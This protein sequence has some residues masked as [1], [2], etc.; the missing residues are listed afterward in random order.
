MNEGSASMSKSRHIR[1][2]DYVNHPY[3]KV[4]DLLRAEALAAF[5]RATKSA[6]ARAETVAAQLHVSIAGI[7][8]GTDI[9]I[10]LHGVEETP[11]VGRSTPVTRLQLEWKARESARL[12][13]LMRAEL[14]V[15]PL[16]ATETQ[17]DFS[18]DY[19]PPLGVVG[20]AVDTLVGHRVAEA[21]IHRFVNEVAEYLRTA[22]R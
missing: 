7:E 20:S 16:T 5:G 2:F 15:Y 6:A 18:G 4:R 14:A 13:P 8:V 12:F 10:K 1:C 22:I 19:E 21:S 11:G 17:L 9:E 3:A